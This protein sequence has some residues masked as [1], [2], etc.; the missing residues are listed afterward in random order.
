MTIKFQTY[1]HDRD[2]L[3]VRDFLVETFSLTAKPLNWKLERWNYARYF[4]TPLLATDGVG[5][6]RTL[7]L[8]NSSNVGAHW[9]TDHCPYD[10]G[11]VDVYAPQHTHPHPCFTPDGRRVVFTSDRTGDAQVYEVGVPA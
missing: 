4:I 2:F 3:R 10:E 11:P 7:C 6:P 9:E 1:E 5:E 8:S